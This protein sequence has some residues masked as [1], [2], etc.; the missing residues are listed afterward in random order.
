MKK[1]TKRSGWLLAAGGVAALGISAYIVGRK[2]AQA[3]NDNPPQGC[4]VDVEGVSLHYTEHGD[5]QAPPL[6][7]L[8]G[9]GSMGEEM[10]LS[11]LVERA[12]CQYRVF[13]FDRPGY[14][15]ST[16][17]GG[18]DYSPQGQ[19]RLFL[20]AL[21]QLCIERPI[22]MAHSWATAIALE[23][24]Q[25]SPAKL[26]GIVLVSGYYTPS[27]RLDM[28]INSAPALPLV[29]RLLAHTISPLLS[30]AIW[31]LLSWR[32]FSP[33]PTHIRHAFTQAYPLWMTLRPSSLRTAA[34]ETAMMLPQA[35]LLMR[36]ALDL[37]VPVMIVA[38][39]QDRLLMTGWHSR[40]LQ[41][42][43]PNSR[44]QIIPNSGH[45]VHHT[46][47]AIVLD[48]I[49]EVASMITPETPVD[50]ASG[51]LAPEDEP[52]ETRAVANAVNP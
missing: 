11:G 2:S 18:Q 30:R 52:Y 12:Q 47:P 14:G 41:Q 51:V 8:H 44:L 29:G 46:D 24:A 5:P 3:E 37:Q 42:R 4:F 7:I 25:Q 19:A 36:H 49:R 45:M 13:V 27:A 35:A 33:D 38:G 43:L 32:I 16:R 50:L 20:K 23:M 22:L 28:L 10:R 17:P 26:K 9:I 1:L 34:Q 21:D 39:A 40:K 31:P 6:V 15:H 48:A